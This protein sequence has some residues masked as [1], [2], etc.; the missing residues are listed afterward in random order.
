ML[1]KA[2]LSSISTK[3]S[4]TRLAISFAKVVCLSIYI[5]QLFHSV[6]T[7]RLCDKNRWHKVIFFL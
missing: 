7:Q 1:T 2:P 6:K 4:C 5:Y 3:I